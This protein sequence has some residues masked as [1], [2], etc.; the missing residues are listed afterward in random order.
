M[1]TNKWLQVSFGKFVKEFKMIT[2]SDHR[3]SE[4]DV[5]QL[6]SQ[7]MTE[8]HSEHMLTKK[9]ATKLRRRQDE[10]V[11][12]Y[13]YTTED[14]NMLVK[15]KKKRS[16]K[17]LNI[18]MENSRVDLS[19][20][21]AHDQVEEATKRLE[22]A[23][24]EQ[25]EADDDA[26]DAAEAGVRKAQ[27]A[28]G[29]AQRKLAGKREERQKIR[30]ED[31]ERRERLRNR[32]TVQNWGKV[33]AR[34]RLANR[35]ADYGA[36]IEQAE[37][38]E[39]EQKFDPYARRRQKPKNLWE[40]GGAPAAAGAEEKKEEAKDAA[41]SVRDDAPAGKDGDAGRP[42]R[43]ELPGPPKPAAPAANRFAF[44]DDILTGGDAAHLGGI[45]RKPVRT[46]ARKGISFEEYQERKT[47]GTL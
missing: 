13:T 27:E 2:V 22:D 36:Y 35:N 40:V 45:G 19:V 4:D 12:N 11:N 21:A 25:M 8:R 24:V 16:H 18:G 17:S 23:K 33:N 47:A 32:S 10:L 7:L 1:S 46:R 30:Q 20:Q 42:R 39:A 38:A 44:D 14:I 31:G 5:T 28:L 29:A 3:P 41:P 9:A 37:R 26:A 15:D 6:V 43:E 34:A